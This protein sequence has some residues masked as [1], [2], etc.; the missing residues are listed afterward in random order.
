MKIVSENL[1]KFSGLCTLCAAGLWLAGHYSAPQMVEPPNIFHDIKSN[2]SGL[3]QDVPFPVH[4]TPYD[5]KMSKVMAHFFIA[6]S[7]SET[8]RPLPAKRTKNTPS[9]ALGSTQGESVALGYYSSLPAQPDRNHEI[10]IQ[11]DFLASPSF[12][13]NNQ[14]D[15]PTP[16]LPTL[17][18]TNLSPSR[19]RFDGTTLILM[20][21]EETSYTIHL[22]TMR[23]SNTKDVLVEGRPTTGSS[24]CSDWKGGCALALYAEPTPPTLNPSEPPSQ[25]FLQSTL[26]RLGSIPPG[27]PFIFPLLLLAWRKGGSNLARQVIAPFAPKWAQQIPIQTRPTF[28]SF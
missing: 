26:M 20:D 8:T 6:P 3:I 21:M 25:T 15:G 28:L 9:P 4:L 23:A 14:L 22:A 7:A 24:N 19:Y 17:F 12:L 18:G 16:T 5:E 13:E 2:H 10:K 11:I 1:I 27:I